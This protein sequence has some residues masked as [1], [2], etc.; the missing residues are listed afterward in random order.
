MQTLALDV[1]KKLYGKRHYQDYTP[2]QVLTG[3]I[4]YFDDWVQEPLKDD[5][6]NDE[7]QMLI[8]MLHSGRL[9]KI[10]P[11]TEQGRT[12][13]YSPTDVFPETM[14]KEHQRYMGEVFNLLNGE[15]DENER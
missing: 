15:D 9:F 13:W 5:K 4:F 10:F 3:F 2:E 6:H 8:S 1:T 14:D 7:R 11:C 12:T